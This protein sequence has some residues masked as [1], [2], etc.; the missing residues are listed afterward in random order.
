MA[1]T[2]ILLRHGQSVYNQKNIF[3]GWTDIELSDQG[4]QEA[5]KA[6][7]ELK[8]LKL[9][10]DVCYTSWLKRAIHT[11]QIALSQMAWEHIDCIKSW[12]L[13]ERHYGAWQQC[14]KDVVK[15]EIGEEAFLS[16]RRGYSTP[17]PPLDENDPRAAKFDPKYRDLDPAQLPKSESLK[18]THARVKEYYRDVL[19]PEL[20]KGKTVLV[21]A[22]GNS[23]RALV[24][25]IEG[26]STDAVVK[27]EIPTGKPL[28]Y[29]YDTG[30]T[31]I[32]K[33][34]VD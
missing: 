31:A 10:P 14:N 2:L 9:Y 32:K 26:L 24:M 21:S 17:P 5:K 28:V 25:E 34:K 4:R 22:H 15:Q 1:S 27:L 13:N 29:R 30:M 12:K 19:I 20:S 8:R 33:V 16:V 3:T 7:T 18:D 6:A 23:L 11:A